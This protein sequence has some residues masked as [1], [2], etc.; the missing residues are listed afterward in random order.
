MAE[1]AFEHG[2]GRRPQ[3]TGSTPSPRGDAGGD[4]GLLGFLDAPELP[5]PLVAAVNGLGL[6]I[7]FTMLAHCDLVFIAEGAR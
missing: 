3:P 6:G 2:Q 5:K 4:A 1:L 7:G